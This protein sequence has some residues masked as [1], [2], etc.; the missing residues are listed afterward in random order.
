YF[1]YVDEL[2][3][4][5]ATH[6]LYIGLLPTWGDKVNRNQWGVGP[7]VFTPEKAQVYGHFLG[8]RYREKSNLIWILGGD[9][10]AVHDQDDSRPLW[11]AMAAGI[12]AGAGFRTLKTY[13]PMGGHSSSIWLHEETWLD[14]NMMQSGHGRGRDTA[15]W[16]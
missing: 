12:D 15:V 14:F 10:P 7:V 5:A 1:A 16:E 11:Q 3:D 6:E 13:H 8:A 2:I 9:R 4:L